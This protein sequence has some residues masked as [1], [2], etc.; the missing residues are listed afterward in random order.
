MAEAFAPTP[1]DYSVKL[2][3][4]FGVPH[5]QTRLNDSSLAPP[6]SRYWIF[7]RGFLAY[8]KLNSLSP[9][10]NFGAG[11]IASN[12]SKGDNYGTGKSGLGD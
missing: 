5:W 7:S 4:F 6:S 8:A 2:K 1:C 11:T 10:F 9:R 3:T 12:Q